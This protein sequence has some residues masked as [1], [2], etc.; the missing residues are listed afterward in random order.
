MGDVVE[1]PLSTV[2]QE[3]WM[4]GRTKGESGTR[5]PSPAE[6][7]SMAERG[8]LAALPPLWAALSEGSLA[9]THR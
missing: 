2:V 3:R 1:F 4:D 7:G 6:R 5:L 9:V 8:S